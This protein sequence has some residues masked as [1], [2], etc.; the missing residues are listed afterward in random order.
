MH[1]SDTKKYRSKKGFQQSVSILF[2]SK[3]AS[4]YHLPSMCSHFCNYAN[5][6]GF[7]WHYKQLHAS[8]KH[9]GGQQMHPISKTV[10]ILF[11]RKQK[12][13]N[14]QNRMDHE[15]RIIRNTKQNL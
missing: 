2:R 3:E 11:M 12:T 7:K 1:K 13:N 8:M 15:Q 14:K 10:H 9:S 6:Q 5:W 4:E